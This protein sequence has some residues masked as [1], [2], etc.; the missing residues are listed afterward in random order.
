VGGAGSGPATESLDRSVECGTGVF[1]IGP[2]EGT[3]AGGIGQDQGRGRE[4]GSW[5]SACHADRSWRCSAWVR[6]CQSIAA[7]MSCSRARGPSPVASSARPRSTAQ[8]AR[9]SR[10]ASSQWGPRVERRAR[11]SGAFPAASAVFAWSR[12]P[13]AQPTGP[14][15]P[16][17]ATLSARGGRRGAG[18][19]E[20]VRERGMVTLRSRLP[21]VAS[22]P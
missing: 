21:A 11:A 9:R 1:G 19:T 17:S 20:G 16:R 3:P 18:G 14:R 10:P 22:F 2:G 13:P 4:P 6:H 12:G 5:P 15:S 8:D 7:C